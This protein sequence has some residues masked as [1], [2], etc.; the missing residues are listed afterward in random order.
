ML[1][2]EQIAGFHTLA[3][4]GKTPA[5]IGDTL[6][7]SSRHFQRMLK[8]ANLALSLMDRLALDEQTVEHC[9]ALCLEDDHT[10]QIEILESVKA[11]WSNASAHLI[12]RAITETEISTDSAKFRFIGRDA[13]E[14]AGGC[15]REE[16]FS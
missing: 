2:A 6:G 4:Q 8:I 7:F 1:P 5:Q 15:V 13:Y 16:L 10:R 3:E 14:A 11:N 12:K 9:Q